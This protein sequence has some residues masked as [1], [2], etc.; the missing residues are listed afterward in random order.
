MDGA[1]FQGIAQWRGLRTI[2]YARTEVVEGEW[3]VYVVEFDSSGIVVLWLSLKS[4]GYN[5]REDRYFRGPLQGRLGSMD[6]LR[7]RVKTFDPWKRNK[8]V[9]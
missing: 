9:P 5:F 7:S 6:I 3:E 8:K 4:K 1:S 2:Y